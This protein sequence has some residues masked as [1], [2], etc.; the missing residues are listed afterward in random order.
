MATIK[1][2]SKKT[3]IIIVSVVLVIAI[4]G[5][6]AA[7]IAIKNKKP[8]VKLSTISTNDIYESVSAT[9]S[10]SSGTVKEY[11]V[12]A[13]ATVKEVFVQTGDQVKEGDRLATFDTSTL[14]TEISKLQNTYNDAKAGY[15]DAVTAQKNSKAKMNAVDKQINAL[16]KQLENLPGAVP[17]EITTSKTELPS[18]EHTTN[19]DSTQETTTR[20]PITLPTTTEP[21][22]VTYPATFEGL[23][24]AVTDLANTI[25]RV[26]ADIESTNELVRIVM[27][28]VVDEINK[29]NLSSDAIAD[30]VGKAVADAIH[31]GIV[32]VIESGE[33]TRMIEAAV[34]AVDWKGVASAIV[35]SNSVQGASLELQITALAAQKEL[36]SVMAS[37]STVKAKK[38]IMNTAKSALDTIK[39]TSAELE[40]GWVA[41]FDGTVTA[42]DLVPGT[43]ASVI[44]GGITIENM[45]SMVVTV[46]LNEYDIHKVKVGMPASITTAYGSY[47]GEVV[48]KA[49]T[50]T[51]GSSGSLLDSVGSMAGISGLSSLTAS[52]AGVEV[53][54]RVDN[55]DEN[56]IIGFD[57][58]VEIQAGSYIGIAVVPIESIVLEKTGTYVYLYN[59]EEGEVSKTLIETGAVSDAFYEVKSGINVG[60][61][62]VSTPSSTFEEDTFKVKVAE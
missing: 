14:N 39:E 2:K 3:T 36:Y 21:E 29:G 32:E 51:G 7:G 15:N 23:I 50:A 56:I 4:I 25:N 35:N 27:E 8:E 22:T 47:T 48:S 53:Q 17:V 58:D 30:K 16:Q 55:P 31:D 18:V 43:Q 1:K 45:D 38:E 61:K 19:E 33:A 5:A 9:G 60:D 12:D 24:M 6:V 37:D 41:T 13:V 26:A 52:G 57:A 44:S 40:A 20:E 28:V 59:E 11:K 49:P 62:I 54:V 42:C 34:K 10:V 46:S